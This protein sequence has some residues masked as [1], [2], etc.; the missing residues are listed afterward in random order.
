[1]KGALGCEIAAVW[2]RMLLSV[3][4]DDIMACQ[5]NVAHFTL[6]G[7]F[8]TPERIF[9]DSV[10]SSS[11]MSSPMHKLWNLLKGFLLPLMSFP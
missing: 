7:N 2:R 1:M 8:L 3:F 4:N 10:S 9:S 11:S 6:A 5:L